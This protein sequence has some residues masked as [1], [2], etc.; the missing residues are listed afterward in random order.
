MR[1]DPAAALLEQIARDIS[2]YKAKYYADPKYL[3]VTSNVLHT[4]KAGHNWAS[5]GYC[6]PN[7]GIIIMGLP[8]AVLYAPEED[9]RCEVVG[10]R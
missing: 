3:V 5:Y 8:V 9:R 4:L 1:D 2:T 7:G 10:N 6:T